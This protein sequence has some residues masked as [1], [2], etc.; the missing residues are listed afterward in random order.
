MNQKYLFVSDLDDTLIGDDAALRRF[1]EFYRALQPDLKLVYASGRFS[2]SIKQSVRSVCLPEPDWVIGG[3]GSEVRKFPDGENDAGWVRR[4]NRNWSAEKVRDA[5]GKDYRLQL[6]SEDSQSAFK[7][8]YIFP[9]ATGGDL[10]NLKVSLQAKGISVKLV[11]SSNRD[12]DVLPYD[13][14]KG[15]ATRFLAESLG[16]P[17]ERVITAGNS[18]NDAALMQYGFKGIVVANA[19]NE[20]KEKAANLGAYETPYPFAD[21]VVDGIKHWM[22]EG[23]G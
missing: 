9:G 16:Y 5:L 14:D 20:L 12:L 17:H 19:H 22:L 2:Q 21:G 23:G 10:E 18:G 13:V 8:S 3:V 1:A 7:V 15:E 6:Q 11:Y 4:M